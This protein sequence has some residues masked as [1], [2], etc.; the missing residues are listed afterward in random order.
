MHKDTE[1]II[2]DTAG[3][4]TPRAA[5]KKRITLPPLLRVLLFLLILSL[6]G[7]YLLNVFDMKDDKGAEK[8]FQTFYL[9]KENTLDGIYI[10]SSSAYR[11]WIP[12]YAYENTGMTVS[13]LGTGSQPVVLQKYIITEALKTQPGMKVIVIDIRSML[14]DDKRL[15]EAD[16]RRVTDSFPLM[17]PWYRPSRNRIQA[18]NAALDYFESQNAAIEYTRGYYYF[19]FLKYH[20]RW[21]SDIGFKDLT[22]LKYKNRFKGFVF[23]ASGSLSVKK[24]EKPDYTGVIADGIDPVKEKVLKDLIDYCK[25]LDQKVIFVS[26]PYQ[27]SEEEQEQLNACSKMIRQAGFTILNFNT[28]ETVDALGLDWQSDFM[29]RKHVNVYGAMKYTEYIMNYLQAQIELTDHRGDDTFQSWNRSAERFHEKLER[30]EAMKE[31]GQ[32]QLNSDE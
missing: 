7:Y 20:N 28:A 9:E 8:V 10:G 1:K 4:D 13:N 19:P 17:D 30:L 25:R 22:G 3:N 12:P 5:E 29:D 18:I 14:N 32:L 15:K 27:I 16:I 21:Q 11:F 31:E 6:L 26:A 2:V 24:L 23:T